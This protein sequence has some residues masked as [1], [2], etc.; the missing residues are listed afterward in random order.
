L[1]IRQFVVSRWR[2]RQMRDSGILI[3]PTL[4]V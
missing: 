4:A 2:L 3:W 1:W